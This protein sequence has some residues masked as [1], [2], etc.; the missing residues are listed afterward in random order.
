VRDQ[1][2]N[3]R[4]AGSEDF[5]AESRHLATFVTRQRLQVSRPFQSIRK[6][7]KARAFAPQPV[8]VSRVTTTTKQVEVEL[9]CI[10]AALRAGGGRVLVQRPVPGIPVVE[11]PAFELGENL[12]HRLGRSGNE[13]RK[14]PKFAMRQSCSIPDWSRRL[15]HEVSAVFPIIQDKRREL[16]YPA[17]A[18]HQDHAAVGASTRR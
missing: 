9:A 17:F 6:A 11:A 12:E 2:A 16:E 1:F 4:V 8:R 7:R 5:Y 3:D 15:D 14:R 13:T 10:F 18:L